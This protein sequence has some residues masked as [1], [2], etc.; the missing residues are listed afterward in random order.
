MKGLQTAL[1]LAIG[2][3][4]GGMIA[5]QSVLNASLGERLGNFGSVLVLT[6]VSALLLAAV[7]LIFP[8]TA[9][10]DSL[11][12]LDEWYLYAGGVLGVAILAA[13]IFLVPRTGVALTLVAIV[14]GQL[15][16]AVV[17]DHFGLFASPRIPVSLPR[18]LGIGLISLGALLTVR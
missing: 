4:A 15:L 18:L 3:T 12:A 17:I 11:P 5:I 14:V 6:L 2:V 10:W 9:R 16:A 8:R 1:M 7:V 13:P